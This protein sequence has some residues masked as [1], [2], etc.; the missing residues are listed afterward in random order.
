MES[1]FSNEVSTIIA[2]VVICGDLNGDGSINIID[3]QS[4]INMVLG[5]IPVNIAIGDVNKDSQI[6][7]LDAQYLVNLILGK[8]SCVQK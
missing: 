5:K 3:L 2:A 6:N 4:L 7:I 1:G 8:T